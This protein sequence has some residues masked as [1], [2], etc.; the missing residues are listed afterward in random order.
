[1]SVNIF[2]MVTPLSWFTALV[3]GTAM[4][5]GRWGSIRLQCLPRLLAAFKEPMDALDVESIA[6]RDDAE[7]RGA[8]LPHRM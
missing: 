3:T 4:V 8:T 2:P 5:S 1:V 7:E 6:I